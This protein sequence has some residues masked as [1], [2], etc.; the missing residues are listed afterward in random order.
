MHN[1][2]LTYVYQIESKHLTYT[3]RLLIATVWTAHLRFF[4]AK[5]I[6][7]SCFHHENCPIVGY[8]LPAIVYTCLWFFP[9]IPTVYFASKW[10]EL[11]AEL[12]SPHFRSTRSILYILVVVIAQSRCYNEIVI[13][14]N[15]KR[16]APVNQISS[17]SLCKL[18]FESFRLNSSRRVQIF[19]AIVMPSPSELFH[20]RIVC[21][22]NYRNI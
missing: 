8:N 4:T 13:I 6:L 1:I 17:T 5:H 2:C 18:S 12:L 15:L 20:F 14:L 22:Q 9:Q 7:R 21:Q 19:N 10:A 3:C 16:Y 11:P